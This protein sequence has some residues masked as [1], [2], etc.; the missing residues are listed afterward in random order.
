MEAN[1]SS[2]C[3][4]NPTHAPLCDRMESKEAPPILPLPL[5]LLSYP[6]NKDPFFGGGRIMVR[7][8]MPP[9]L[10]MVFWVQGRLVITGPCKS[11]NNKESYF[12]SNILIHWNG[13]IY[14]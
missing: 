2:D 5:F 4:P 10:W 3:R 1:P 9:A 12:F 6:I 13:I 8:E 11:F 7:V 14:S